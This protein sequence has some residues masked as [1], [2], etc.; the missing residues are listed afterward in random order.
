MFKEYFENLGNELVKSCKPAKGTAVK[1]A[2]KGAGKGSPK[3]P[4]SSAGIQPAAYDRDRVRELLAT[5]VP[6]HLT[7]DAV[8]IADAGGYSPEGVDF[9]I[10]REMFRNMDAMMS[11][12]PSDLAYGALFVNTGLSATSIS[13]TLTRVANMKKI[14]RFGDPQGAG[15]FLPAFVLSTDMHMTFQDLKT[16][17]LDFYVSRSLDNFFEFD[18]MAIVNLGIV[19]KDWREKRSFKILDT[20]ADTMKWFFILLNEYLDV[21]K[22]GSLDLRKYVKESAQYREY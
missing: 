8:K 17:I 4:A 2:E 12:V 9:V 6:A 14:D 18:I 15:K 16:L 20:G 10:Y 1:T 13:E 5:L 11:A 21:E 22:E 3:K 7:L 19:V